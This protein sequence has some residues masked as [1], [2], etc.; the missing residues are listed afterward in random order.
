MAFMVERIQV[1]T[2]LQGGALVS[3]G[4]CPKHRQQLLCCRV[5]ALTAP[6]T[7]C[8]FQCSTGRG[9]LSDADSCSL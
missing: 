3:K 8:A 1:W 5:S 9:G 6:S 4:G 2:G 7:C